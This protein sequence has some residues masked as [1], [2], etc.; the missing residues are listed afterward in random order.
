MHLGR[1]SND[2]VYVISLCIDTKRNCVQDYNTNSYTGIALRIH[3]R[4]LRTDSSWP[5]PQSLQLS[6]SPSRPPA[7]ARASQVISTHVAQ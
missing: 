3:V 6:P 1:L 2:Q 5:T 7:S 4:M